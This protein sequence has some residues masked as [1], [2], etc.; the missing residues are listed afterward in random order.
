MEGWCKEDDEGGDED[1]DEIDDEDDDD[2]DTVESSHVDSTY[3]TP[4][5]VNQK[6]KRRLIHF[7]RGFFTAN[8]P[9]VE[10]LKF[11][12]KILVP[13]CWCTCSMLDPRILLEYILS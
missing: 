11:V 1:D 7:D 8:D 6:I 13:A 12:Y 2:D 4:Q 9:C 10:V 3:S 5:K